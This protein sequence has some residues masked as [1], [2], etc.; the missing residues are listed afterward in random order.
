MVDFYIMLIYL[1]NIKCNTKKINEQILSPI[2]IKILVIN[3]FLAYFLFKTIL[4]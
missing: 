2:T 1:D 4:G 3:F